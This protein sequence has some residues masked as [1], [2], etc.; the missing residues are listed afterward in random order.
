M[1]SIDELWHCVGPN[2]RSC[3]T[4]GMEEPPELEIMPNPKWIRGTI[5]GRTV[6]DTRDSVLV[7]ENRFYPAW[8]TPRSDIDGVLVPNGKT[9]ESSSRGV[10]TCYDLEIGETVITD[11]AIVH[12]DAVADGLSDLVRVNWDAVDSWFEEDVEVFVHPRS[13]HVRVDTLRSSRHVRVFVDGVMLADTRQSTLLFETGLPTRYYLP[14]LD[15]RMELLQPT[16]TET[17]CPYKGWASYWD[18]DTGQQRH[19]DLAW[20]YRTTLPEASGVA[21]LVCFY[22]EHVALEVDGVEIAQPRTIF[23]ENLLA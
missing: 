15:V 4:C 19:A 9:L 18:V 22:N 3:E 5:D 16:K 20:G 12:H 7:W 14:K 1:S 10:G 11:A 6:V 17:A 23:S 13:P 2:G 8:Y 21:G